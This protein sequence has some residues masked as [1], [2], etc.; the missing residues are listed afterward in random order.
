MTRDELV[1][2]IY[3]S[4]E[5]WSCP[6]NHSCESIEDGSPAVLCMQCADKLLKEYEAKIKADAV[7]EIIKKINGRLSANEICLK[8]VKTS[9]DFDSVLYYEHLIMEDKIAIGFAKELL[10]P[11]ET[12]FDC[13]QKCAYC[14]KTDLVNL[15]N[16]KDVA[17]GYSYAYKVDCEGNRYIKAEE[18]KY[19]L[20]KC[21]ADAIDECKEA[22]N[23]HL[24]DS[25]MM[26]PIMT[27]NE[28]LLFLD[29]LKEQKDEKL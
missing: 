18:V 11:R 6:D 26:N 19:L 15:S 14:G 13:N 1:K 3:D 24:F 8:N 25:P 20:D 10:E 2:A 17:I 23:E 7:N 9:G 4:C 29:Q 16:G 12:C 21:R 27:R 28:I 5:D 22:F